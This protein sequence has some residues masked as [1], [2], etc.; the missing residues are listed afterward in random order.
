MR[1]LVII[2]CGLPILIIGGSFAGIQGRLAMTLDVAGASIIPY[3]PWLAFV[4]FITGGL[5]SIRTKTLWVGVV[6]F[7]AAA[8]VGHS[9]IQYPLMVYNR[10]VH[11]IFLSREPSKELRSE[12]ESHFK[13]KTV[14][15]SNSSEGDLLLIRAMDFSQNMEAFIKSAEQDLPVKP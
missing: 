5:A 10:G 2:I 3:I 11:K 1:T 14:W 6:G 13:V 9:I 7:I 15:C 8:L 4:I 12:F